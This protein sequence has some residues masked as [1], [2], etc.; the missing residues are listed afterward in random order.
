MASVTNT[1]TVYPSGYDT[2]NYSYN[3]VNSSY[4]LTNPVGKSSDNTTYAQWTMKTGSS[5]ETYVFYLFDLSAIPENAMIESVSCTAKAYIS[6]TTTSRIS[7]RTIQLYS[8]ST[9]K[10]SSTN[11]STSTTALTM[12]CGEWTRAELEDCRIRIYAKRG[13]SQT[14]TSVNMRFY[15]ATLTVTYSVPE[16]GPTLYVKENGSYRAYSSVYKKES[17]TWVL[18]ADL[19]SVFSIDTNYVKAN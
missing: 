10:G 8:G 11:I 2:T 3:T 13:T 7:A 9:A 1:L 19:G 16:D 4:P 15:G 5:A 6:S 18:Q 12:T 14:S 17:G